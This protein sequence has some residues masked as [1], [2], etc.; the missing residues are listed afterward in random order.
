VC[1]RRRRLPPPPQ[2]PWLGEKRT[3][4]IGL[5]GFTVQCIMVGL[6]DSPRVIFASMGCSLLTNNFYPAMS[7][8]VKLQA[9]FKSGV[10]FNVLG[11]SLTKDHFASMG[12]SLLT[13][14]FYP[15]M[16]RC[17]Q[18]QVSTSSLT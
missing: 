18:L 11:L 16:S 7:R 15:A 8:C 9:L 2:V 12:C 13:S 10:Q 5:V 6:A 1:P 14:N 3:M 4:Q 17:A